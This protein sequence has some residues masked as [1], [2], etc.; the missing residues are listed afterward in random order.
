MPSTFSSRLRTAINPPRF[1]Y[2]AQA[3]KQH[4]VPDV[5]KLSVLD[6]GCGGGL[7]SERFAALGCAVTG[8]DQS[9]PSL[10][11]ARGHAQAAGLRI[12][13]RQGQA[14]ALPVATASVDVVCCC[15]VLEH[16]DDVERVIAEIARVLK[17][18]GLFFFD[19]INRTW[20]SKLLAIK[21][22][23]DWAPTRFVP[24]DVHV[25]EHFIRP[26]ELTAA[27]QRNGLAAQPLVGL[28]PTMNPLTLLA[29]FARL[30]LGKINFA[31]FG[32]RLGLR[33]SSDVSVSY[34]DWARRTAG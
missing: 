32:R 18:G 20:R 15:D 5:T 31:E 19:T 17:P 21:L 3:L 10:E 25:W 24:R 23:Q 29:A 9:E 26:A 34:M 12:A 7:L 11:A 28:S 2:F 16:V 13:Y 33:P 22:A 30:K 6:V 27:L 4:A 8:I 14:Q 1:A